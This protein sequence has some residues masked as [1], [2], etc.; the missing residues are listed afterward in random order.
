M[1]LSDDDLLSFDH[2]RLAHFDA[3]DARKALA[4]QRDA[5]RSQLVA[6]RWID[7]WLEGLARDHGSDERFHE[8]FMQGL[9]EVAANLRQGDLIPGGVLHD[10]TDGR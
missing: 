4:E 9:R 2:D 6:A 3:D 5:Y 8:G 7:F 1:A 10:E